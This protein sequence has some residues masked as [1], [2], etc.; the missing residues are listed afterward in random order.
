MKT[1]NRIEVVEEYRLAR[2]SLSGDLQLERSSSGR[3]WQIHCYDLPEE[4]EEAIAK[5]PHSTEIRLRTVVE[6]KD[7][8]NNV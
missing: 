8:T 4:I 1:N 7:S 6:W 3:R 5:M 2:E